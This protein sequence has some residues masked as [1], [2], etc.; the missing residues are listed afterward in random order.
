MGNSIVVARIIPARRPAFQAEPD[1]GHPR[2]H[3][4]D[5]RAEDRRHWEHPV[6]VAQDRHKRRRDPEGE[7]Q[8]FQP[9]P[10]AQVRHD[11]VAVA[12]HFAHVIARDRLVDIGGMRVEQEGGKEDEAESRERQE[13]TGSNLPQEHVHASPEWA[14]KRV[15]R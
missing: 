13:R 2:H 12:Q 15:G 4:D 8:P 10:P 3:Q 14:V 9:R 11:P 1:R 6:I 5:R 7:Q